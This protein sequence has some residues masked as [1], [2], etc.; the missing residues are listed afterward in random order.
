MRDRKYLIAMTVT[1]VFASCCIVASAPIKRRSARS[2][3]SGTINTRVI[4]PDPLSL[5]PPP[6]AVA[7]LSPAHPFKIQPMPVRGDIRPRTPE[8]DELID[9]AVVIMSRA[10][11]VPPERK[12]F[13][14]WAN[15]ENLPFGICG[16]HAFVHDVSAIPGGWLISMTVRPKVT[17]GFQVGTAFIEEYSWVDGEL[18]FV[19]GY[20]HPRTPLGDYYRL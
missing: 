8:Q 15:G 18:G 6:E 5:I 20:K 2:G 3:R 14:S 10:L 17:G 11:P 9:K 4:R 12:Q 19:R 7:Q 16:W 13:F 1:A